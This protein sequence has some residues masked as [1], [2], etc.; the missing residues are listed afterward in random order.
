MIY[1]IAAVAAVISIVT[2]CSESSSERQQ[3]ASETTE[4]QLPQAPADPLRA[5]G[6]ITEITPA[7][8]TIEQPDGTSATFLL[9]QDYSVMRSRPVDIEAI[10]PGAYVATANTNIDASSGR[11][12]ELRMFDESIR[13]VEFSR[14]MAEPNTTMTN[15]TVQTITKGS[16]GRELEVAY[17]GGTRKITVPAEVEVFGIFPATVEDLQSGITIDIFAEPAAT[18]NPIARR[19]TIAAPES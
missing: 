17:Q 16:G 13:G 9:P 2:G 19:I 6:V 12:I 10:K 4:A 3:P 18:G 15:G 11:S 14:P 1:R 5:S 8:L 7:A